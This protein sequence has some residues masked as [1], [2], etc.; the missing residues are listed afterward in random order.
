MD[1]IQTISAALQTSQ[2]L[3]RT[4]LSVQAIKSAARADRA[5]AG[6]LAEHAKAMAAESDPRSKRISLYI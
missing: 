6:M 1:E 5:L 2:S 4:G 3:L